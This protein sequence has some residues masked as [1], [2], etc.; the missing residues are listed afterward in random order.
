MYMQTTPMLQF[1]NNYFLLT[2]QVLFLENKTSVILFTLQNNEFFLKLD[3][4]E[5]WY[6][7]NRGSKI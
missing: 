2:V 5:L 3:V 6:Q 4:E 7:E 1:Y